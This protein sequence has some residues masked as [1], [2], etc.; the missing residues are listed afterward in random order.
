MKCLLDTNVLIW[1]TENSTI[2][3]EKARQAIADRKNLK[4]FSI[5][6][7]WEIALKLGKNSLNIE[8]GLTAV[9]RLADES[10]FIILPVKREYIRLLSD[11]PFHH[12]DP[13]DRLLVSS[14]MVEGMTIITSDSEI[15]M[16]DVKVIW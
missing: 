2:L 5:I 6:S 16:Y 9:E 7:F 12:K 14:A 11:M 8:G 10:G 4:Y 15:P 3:S 1:I 13:F